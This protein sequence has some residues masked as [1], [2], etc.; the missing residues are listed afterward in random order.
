VRGALGIK[1][2]NMGR[3]I[4]HADMDA[5]YASVEQRDRP[6][7]AGQPVIVGGLGKRGVVSTASYEAR[8]FGVHSAMPTAQARR[9]CPEGVFLTGRMEA[10]VEASHQIREAFLDYTDLIE[11]L[12]LDE[13]FLDVTGSVRLFGDGR[14]IAESLRERVWEST[15][16][17]VSVGV[18]ESKFMAKVASDQQKPDGLTVVAPGGEAAFL[19]PLP[20]SRLW[21]VGKVTQN[22]MQARGWRTI[23]DIQELARETLVAE[24]G[25]SS[26]QHYY[27]L[28]RGLDDRPVVPERSPLSVSRETT[29]EDDLLSDVQ[30]R[31]TLLSL[32]EDVGM[33]LRRKG[34]SGETVR[35]K[36]RF[37]PFRTLTRQARMQEASHDDMTIYKTALELLEK[38]RTSG[39]AVRLIGVGMTDLVARSEFAQSELFGNPVE[40][41]RV[42]QTLDEIRVRFGNTAAGRG[43]GKRHDEERPGR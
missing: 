41:G 19:A 1:M 33:R 12:S 40:E 23:A 6:E 39:Q 21:G 15:H 31:A 10:Y 13:A 27:A 8:R 43:R 34:L 2:E 30:L 9:L 35:L 32:S 7:L 20:V 5:F 38:V 14:S 11:P 42:D 3:V 22:R 26:G 25:A 37:P 24:F 16:L 18:A 17:R 36:I 28:C 4:L 29:F